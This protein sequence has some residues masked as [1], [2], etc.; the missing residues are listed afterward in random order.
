MADKIKKS[1]I[2]TNVYVGLAVRYSSIWVPVLIV[3]IFVGVLIWPAISKV[4]SLSQNIAQ[5]QNDITTAD[6]STA[7]VKKMKEDLEKFKEKVAEF[8][9]KLPKRMKTTLI[10]ETLQEITQKSRLK[11]SSLEPLPIKKYKIEETNDV[12]VELPVKVRL[13]CGYYDLIEFI[14][15]IETANQLM[16]ITDLSIKDDPSLDWEHI[17]EFSISAY[18]KGDTDDQ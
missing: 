13:N 16:K 8:E 3:A 9:N 5:K 4:S 10:I 1:S 11:F 17:V 15:R 12:F 7:N 2:S 18:S 6:R 14:K